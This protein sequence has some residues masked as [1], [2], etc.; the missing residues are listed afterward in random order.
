MHRS[1]ST[2]TTNHSGWVSDR[3]ISKTPKPPSASADEGY[4]LGCCR[5]FCDDFRHR[6]VLR[7]YPAFSSW[8]I[9]SSHRGFDLPPGAMGRKTDHGVSN[10]GTGT[11]GLAGRVRI[12]RRA[13]R[14]SPSGR[15]VPRQRRRSITPLTDRLGPLIA[16][17]LEPVPDSATRVISGEHGHDGGDPQIGQ[18]V[19]MRGVVGRKVD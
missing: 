6:P 12:R 7:E 9:S 4:W 13:N 16:P 11:A 8:D 2:S 19:R 14:Y 1:A 17:S 10:T 3:T 18:L 15:G 5:L